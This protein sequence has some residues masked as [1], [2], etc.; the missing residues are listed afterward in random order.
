MSIHGSLRID[1][2]NYSTYILFKAVH[3]R[4]VLP[5]V[6]KLMKD[7]FLKFSE[8]AVGSST[9]GLFSQLLIT[10]AISRNDPLATGT[11]CKFL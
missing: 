6:S 5:R 9:K 4:K 8:K 11:F 2:R 10:Y 3:H 7:T 1:Q